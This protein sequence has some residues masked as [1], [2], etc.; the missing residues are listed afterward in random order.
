MEVNQVMQESVKPEQFT[1][2]YA[3]V[4]EGDER[5]KVLPVPEGARFPGTRRPPT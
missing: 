4:F 3:S 1:T 2:Q 5:W